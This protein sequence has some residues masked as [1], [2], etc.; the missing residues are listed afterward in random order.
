[1]DAMTPEQRLAL[2]AR[3]EE[4]QTTLAHSETELTEG[5]ARIAFLTDE[6]KN[7]PRNIATES[8]VAQN[9]QYIKPKILDL[10]LQRSELL[11]KYAPTS[12]KVRDLDRQ[13]AEW[14]LMNAD[15]ETPR[16]H[17]R[18]QP[19]V[20]EPR[21]RSRPDQAQMARVGARALRRR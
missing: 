21:S 6:I 19:R 1:M 20:S 18:H 5:T 13:I 3:L 7:Y 10:E 17:E 11:A 9:Q 14:R 16:N 4:L 12:V 2:R 15:R 8:K